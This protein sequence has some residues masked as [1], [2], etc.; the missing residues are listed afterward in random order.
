MKKLKTTFAALLLLAGYNAHAQDTINANDTLAQSV[1]RVLSDLDALKKIKISGYIQS[2][3]QVA[4]SSGI[5]SFEGGDFAPGVDKR[6]AVRRGRLKVTYDNTL[7]QYVLQ[8]DVTEKGVT[9]KDAYVKVTEP[10]LKSFSLTAGMQNRPF[11]F[12]VPFSSSQRESPERGRMSQI[13]FPGE[14][15]LGAMITFQAP[16]SSPW[17]T[18]KIEAGMFNG[19]GAPSPAKDASDFDFQKDFIGHISMNQV[20]KSEKV[21]YGLGVSYYDGGFRQSNKYVYNMGFVKPDTL[22]FIIDSADVNK[23]AI[24]K[25]QYIGADAQVSFEF[26]FGITTLRGEY[27]QGEQPGTSSTTKSPQA[28]PAADTYKRKFNGAYLYFLQNIG[29]SKHQVV[30][31]YDWYD[32]NT[33]VSG[34]EIGR[35]KSKL[36]KTDL[37]YSTLGLGWVY[38]WDHNVKFTTYYAMVTNETSKNLAGYSK[39]LKDNVLTLRVQYKF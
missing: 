30:V 21:K 37:K 6:F 24:A 4:D 16:K 22:G 19:T 11:G 20:S 36:N 12:E 8:F 13:I 18:L 3:F 38:H 9:I 35:S 32:P 23:G 10:W 14:R 1:S 25:R 26:P 31:K 27:I 17:S 2:Q 28:D 15:D 34:D 29:Q 5:S 39:D 7:T 33:E